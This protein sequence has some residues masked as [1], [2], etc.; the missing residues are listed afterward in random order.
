M[1]TKQAVLRQ[2]YGTALA[3]KSD[4]NHWIMMDGAPMAGGTDA[5]SRPKELVLIALGGCTAMDVL[6]ILKKKRAPLQGYEMRI[7]G[8]E[9]EEHPRVFTRIHLEYI[10]YGEGIAASD[11]E[12]AIELS[13]TKYCSVS[14][15]L[16]S[17]VEI[18]H[19]YRIEPAD[20]SVLAPQGVLA[21]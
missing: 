13:T 5:A 11:V 6:S 19:S 8:T 10:F 17:S 4:S 14:A 16:R 21:D 9:A 15:M 18:T 1:A 7:T 3:A 2:L 12:K 20:H